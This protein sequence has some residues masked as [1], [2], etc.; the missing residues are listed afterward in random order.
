M[1]EEYNLELTEITSKLQQVPK[2]VRTDSFEDE[3]NTTLFNINLNNG[4][5]EGEFLKIL[6]Y[7]ED[8]EALLTTSNYQIDYNLRMVF[9]YNLCYTYI[10]NSDYK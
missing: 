6:T 5:I 10:G 7:T 2:K 9:Q 1:Y 4:L 8:I 3:L